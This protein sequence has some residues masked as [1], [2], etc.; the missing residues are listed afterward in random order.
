MHDLAFFG[1]CLAAMSIVMA[2]VGCQ[3]WPSPGERIVL[4]VSRMATARTDLQDRPELSLAL[5]QGVT[6][7]EVAQG[8]LVRANCY[9]E[10]GA[11]TWLMR[12]GFV[13]L[14]Q[15][16]RAER[17]TILAIDA[18]QALANPLPFTGYFGRYLATLEASPADYF[19]SGNWSHLFRCNPGTATG[20]MRVEVSSTVHNWEWAFAAAE[21]ERNSHITDD[22][23]RAGRIALA[24][25]SPGMD[26]W[27]PYKVRLPAGLQVERGDFIEAVA[28]AMDGGAATGDIAV[29]LRRVARPPQGAFIGVQGD[30]V[31][32]CQAPA[33]AL[34]G[35]R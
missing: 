35:P 28:G 8:R 3:A 32:S 25:C 23:L 31:V 16:M 15:G 5:A 29:A 2:L 26:S 11:A 34:P 6:R 4:Q 9:V 14:P 17:G 27:A 24:K 20:R 1:R 21:A 18:Q 10:T 12:F 30:K 22:E 19:D 7:Q 33:V 13:L